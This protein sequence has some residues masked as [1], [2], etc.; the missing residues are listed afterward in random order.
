MG[1][2]PPPPHPKQPGQGKAFLEIQLGVPAAPR[3]GAPDVRGERPGPTHDPQRSTFIH[4]DISL[5]PPKETREGQCGNC[6]LEM[7]PGHQCEIWTDDK[8]DDKE[9][10]KEE[11]YCDQCYV[12]FNTNA[13]LMKHIESNHVFGLNCANHSCVLGIIQYPEKCREEPGKCCI[14]QPK[15]GFEKYRT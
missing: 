6:G 13:H 5:S 7:S 8:Q 9:E 3:P 10:T 1:N 15:D 2:K 4:G 12:I 14:Y 11:L